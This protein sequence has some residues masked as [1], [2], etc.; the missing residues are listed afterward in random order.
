MISGDKLR[1]AQ[2]RVLF[3]RGNRVNPGEAGNELLSSGIEGRKS[4]GLG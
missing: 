3:D 2:E 1:F 4:G